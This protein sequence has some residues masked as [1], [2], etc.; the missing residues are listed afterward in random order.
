M[1]ELLSFFGGLLLFISHIV[2]WGCLWF[3]IFGNTADDE[4][5]RAKTAFFIVFGSMFAVLS[6]V[7]YQSN[8][9][10]IF[11]GTVLGI[12]LVVLTARI[13]YRKWKIY[14][15]L[16][17]GFP[18]VIID[19]NGTYKFIVAQIKDKVGNVKLIVR[20]DRTCSFHR[21]ILKQVI[22]KETEE[23]IP[24]QCIGGGVIRVI[25]KEKIIRIFG[26]SQDFGMEPSRENTRLMLE[27][28][29]PEFQ[30]YGR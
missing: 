9:S 14:K 22:K 1:D 30:V 17:V 4:Y 5:E 27:K 23:L 13:I 3:A 8:H 18:D 29:F 16:K 21:E 24:I 10:V 26:E 6:V 2:V 28:A 19:G 12:A 15:K 25:D 20:A 11:L 7:L